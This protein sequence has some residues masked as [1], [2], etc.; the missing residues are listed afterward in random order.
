M[1]K[2]LILA[3]ALA[4]LGVSALALLTA[5]RQIFFPPPPSYTTRD[6]PVQLIRST[7]GVEIA[8][9]H[10]R[11]P[12]ATHT[13]LFS[14]GNAEDLGS[15]G[16]FLE[17]IRDHGFSVVAWDYRGYGASTGGRPTTRGAYADAEAVWRHATE[18][19]RIPPSRIILHG[20][21][22]G[23]GPAIDLATRVEAAGL[24][25]ESGFTSA[26]RVVT[27]IPILPFDPIPNLRRLKRV[28]V[29]VLVIHGL[30]DDIIQ[31]WHGRALFAA[32]RGPKRALWVE[33]AGHNDL[34]WVAGASYWRALDDFRELLGE[35]R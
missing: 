18:T 19:L 29:P 14:H 4:W 25:I 28:D 8:V 11:H 3:I 27:R 34:L 12:T 26:F 30:R 13:I 22:V 24:V 32:A 31:P 7:D 5:D 15:A 33:N 35:P 21:S 10:L 23:T 9:L 2:G 6:L 16:A 17:Q 20:R 1:L